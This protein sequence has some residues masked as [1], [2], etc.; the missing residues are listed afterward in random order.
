M[1]FLDRT[2][3]APAERL[4]TFAQIFVAV[5]DPRISQHNI[6]LQLSTYNPLVTARLQQMFSF[7]GRFAGF[8]VRAF[9]GRIG[10]IQGFLHSS[11]CPPIECTIDKSARRIQLRL[12]GFDLK[13][14]AVNKK[15]NMLLARLRSRARRLGFWPIPLMKYLGTPGEGQHIGA[16]FPM[17]PSLSR[18]MDSVNLVGEHQQ[19]RRVHVVDSSVLPELPTATITFTAMANAF[20]I[21]RDVLNMDAGSADRLTRDVSRSLTAFSEIMPEEPSNG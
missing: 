13:R 16:T 20:R 7:L 15:F 10:A 9:E 4:Y 18:R 19:L 3:A 5:L 1:L 6:H 8:P 12:K 14:T 21:T 11:E 2:P 17:T